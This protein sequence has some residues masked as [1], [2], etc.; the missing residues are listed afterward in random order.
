MMENN[1]DEQNFNKRKK[2]I[3]PPSVEAELNKDPNNKKTKNIDSENKVE[4]DDEKQILNIEDA[5]NEI[6]N[7]RQIIKQKEKEY[8]LLQADFVNFQKRTKKNEEERLKYATQDLA[9]ALIKQLDVFEQALSIDSDADIQ[10]ILEG[11]SM[12]HQGIIRVL[13]EYNVTEIEV[14]PG[15]SVDPEIHE[16]MLTEYNDDLPNNS[17]SKILL[18]GYKLYDRV[19]RATKIISVQNN[20]ENDQADAIEPKDDKKSETSS[21][22]NEQN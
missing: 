18:K 22:Q 1:K 4:Q 16:V 19:I 8:L 6:E 7:L 3:L 17:V 12:I 20:V 11:F 21:Q 10:K 14:K 15:D 9:L 5:L 2:L 13:S